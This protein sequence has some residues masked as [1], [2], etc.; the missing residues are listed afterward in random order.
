MK[1]PRDTS[2]AHHSQSRRETLGWLMKVAAREVLSRLSKNHVEYGHP[3]VAV[4][5]FDHIGT[6]I[7]LFGRYELEQLDL[8]FTWCQKAGICFAGGDAVDIGA[9]IG[10][11]SLYFSDLFQQVHA[12]E[13]NPYIFSLLRINA[14]LRHNIQAYNVGCSDTET[15]GELLVPKTNMGAGSL[16][17]SASEESLLIPVGLEPLDTL[18]SGHAVRL[19]KID[20]EGHELSVLKGARAIIER[21]RPIVI[22]ESLPTYS[23]QGSVHHYM[24]E[25]GYHHFVYPDFPEQGLSEAGSLRRAFRAAR[26][27]AEGRTLRLRVTDRTEDIVGL[28]LPFVAALPDWAT[29]Q[30]GE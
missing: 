8:F 11:H 24:E 10:N 5:A 7:T 20:V 21:D 12:Y 26:I 30:L 23:G 9:N 27:L 17:G 3:Q 4:R 2:L 22:Y 13:P 1:G 16:S 6:Q 15:V 19:I 14:A 18:L 29:G 28:S 25:L